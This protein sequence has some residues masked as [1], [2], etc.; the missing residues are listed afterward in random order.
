MQSI[1]QNQVA[2][3]LM[4]VIL[5]AS[6][7][8]VGCTSLP[9]Q[10]QDNLAKTYL[11]QE[12]EGEVDIQ[13]A[14]TAPCLTLV[15]NKMRAAPGFTTSRIA[16]VQKDYQQDY[17]A[18]HQWTDTPANMLTAIVTHALE[19]SHLFRAVVESPT[20]ITSDLRL[21]S[22]LLHLQQ[23]FKDGGSIVQLQLR[24]I[25][26]DQESRDVVVSHTFTFSE[27]V[28]ENT[29]YGGVVAANRAVTRLVPELINFIDK[30]THDHALGCKG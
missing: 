10:R 4:I 20:A 13:V 19:N 15:V 5:S 7:V 9:G 6:L 11:L 18:S 16:Y 8:L 27:T 12:P 29:P 26:I 22:E 17:F 24:I 2:S 30:A 28:L 14:D 23:V 1:P 21:D 3:V 25:L